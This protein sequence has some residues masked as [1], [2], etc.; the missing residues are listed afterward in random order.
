MGTLEKSNWT[1]RD[2]HID[3]IVHFDHAQLGLLR[4]SLEMLAALRHIIKL[5]SH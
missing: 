5:I 3:G 1:F 4:K 2:S